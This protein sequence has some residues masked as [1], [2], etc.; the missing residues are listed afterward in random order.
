[1]AT[2]WEEITKFPKLVGLEFNEEKT[3]S[4]F[5]WDGAL[6][7]SL[8]KGDIKW[9]F[10]KFHQ[11]G[12]FMIDQSRVGLHITE[13]KRQ[14]SAA[15]KQSI[16]AWV[17]AYNKYV[18]SFFINNF[19]F[20]TAHC[21]GREHVATVIE[22]LERIHHAIFPEHHGSVTEYLANWI[23]RDFDITRILE[24]WFYW[25]I[26]M[27]GLEAKDLFIV[28]NSVWRELY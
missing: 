11:T 18:F 20:P 14:L 26:C 3:G 2:A 28:A 9:G 4:S 16:F 5:I 27:G 1:M 19:S 22:T 10:L 7:P 23:K 15:A 25:P 17:T 21:F 6:H 8:P 12:K 24:G 13:P